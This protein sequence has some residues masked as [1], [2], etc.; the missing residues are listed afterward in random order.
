VNSKRADLVSEIEKDVKEGR[1]QCG[2][3]AAT[4]RSDVISDPE[5]DENDSI[6]IIIEC[7]AC[8]HHDVR[9]YSK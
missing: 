2:H 5:Y 7:R 8:D 6:T 1:V 3:C 4:K 9:H